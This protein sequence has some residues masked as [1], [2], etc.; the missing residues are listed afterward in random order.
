MKKRFLALGLLAIGLLLIPLSALAQDTDGGDSSEDE[1][2][3]IRINGD[4]SVAA[5]QTFSVVIVINGDITVD[6]TIEDTLVVVNGTATINGTVGEEL[7]VVRGDL[8][9]TS[10]AVVEDVMLVSSDLVRDPAATVNGDLEERSGDFSFGRGLAVF[11][12][13]WWVGSLIV[14]L[15][16]AALFAWLGRRQLFESIETLRGSF[17][18]SLVTAL[19]VWILL[20][21]IAVLV[22]FTVIGIPLTIS[23]FLVLLPILWSLGAIVIAAWIG[24]YAFKPDTIGRAIGAALLGVVILA[25]ISLIPFI[26]PI[27]GLAGM[28]GAG[29][30]V[31]RAFSRTTGRS[32]AAPEPPPVAPVAPPTA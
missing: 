16:A 20:P 26:A 13:I 32:D 11:S 17:V 5:D 31:Y 23:I 3:T 28:L 10:T 6:G 22:A 8:N 1:D 9:L 15:V 21:I 25:V 27:V 12:T 24:S 29:A 4:L 30:L 7:V 2:V 18:P 19:I 14:G